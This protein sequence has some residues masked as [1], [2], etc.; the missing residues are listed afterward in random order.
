MMDPAII[1]TVTGTASAVAGAEAIADAIKASGAII[2]TG[3][4]RIS[5]NFVKKREPPHRHGIRR[6][7]L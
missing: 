1:G 6:G 5:E 7:F 3:T 2:R 4:E